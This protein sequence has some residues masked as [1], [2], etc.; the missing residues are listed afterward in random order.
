DGIRDFHVTGVQT[1]ALPISVRADT[2]MRWLEQVGL[3]G[4]EQKYPNQLSGGM[5]Q[6]V[7]LARALANDAPVLLM[8]EAYSA[9]D[10]LIRSDMRSEERRVG[11]GA[12]AGGARPE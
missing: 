3:K 2:A 5:Q 11:D 7:G 6:R 8:D 9:L 4:F 1:C 10:P 12:S